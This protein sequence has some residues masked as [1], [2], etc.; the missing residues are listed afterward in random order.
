M[1]SSEKVFFG[2]ERH[3]MKWSQTNRIAAIRAECA[4]YVACRPPA[5][6]VQPTPFRIF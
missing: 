1:D 2:V 6:S 3:Q 5:D 4:R